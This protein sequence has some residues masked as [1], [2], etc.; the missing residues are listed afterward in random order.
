ME[1]AAVGLHTWCCFTNS[2]LTGRSGSLLPIYAECMNVHKISGEHHIKDSERNNSEFTSCN[3]CR[4]DSANL[5]PYKIQKLLREIW[6]A[7]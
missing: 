3:F 1:V 2:R 4:D 6:N 7:V 5:P